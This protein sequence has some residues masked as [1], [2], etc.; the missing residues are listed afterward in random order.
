MKA[1]NGNQW[2]KRA[3]ISIG[4]V[5]I[6]FIIWLWFI[7]NHLPS[8]LKPDESKPIAVLFSNIRVISMVDENLPSQSAQDV[9]IIGDRIA[10][11]GATG[12]IK[13]PEGVL[14]IDG[15]GYTLMPG[16]IDAHIHLNDE[17]EF[18]AY[19]AHGVTGLRNMSGYPFHLQLTERITKGQLL[20]PDFMTT[21]PIL[22]SSGPNEHILQTIV[23]T[24][25]EARSAVR[26]QHS[27]GYRHIKVYSNLTPKAFTTILEEATLLGMT[28]S[29][30]SP[31]GKRTAGIPREKPFEIPWEASLG[32]GL[33]T[34]EHIE[35]IV[36]HGLR[37]DLTR[38]KMAVL[39]ET[40]AQSGEAVTPTLIAHKRLVLIAQSKGAY[41]TRPGSDMIN[42]LVTWFSQGALEYWSQMDP[43]VY[44]A[45]H[46]EFFLKATGLLHQ[47]GVPLLT[48]TDSGSFGII[49]GESV[50]H[51]LE[52]LVAAGLSPF[53]ALRS[54]TRRNAEKLGFEKTGMIL[55]GYRANLVLLAKDPLTDVS[56][57]EHP[58]GVMI[59]GHWLEQQ[60]LDAL[61]DSARSS[62]VSSFFRSLIRVI[63]MKLTH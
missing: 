9:L 28:I 46:A 3:G 15:E 20:A 21:G 50:A 17:L 39:A 52:L 57:V 34:L 60:E 12:E 45:P 40:I 43:S 53:D 31:E 1:K 11:I 55:S 8:T 16:L 18:A 44:E 7:I 48:G 23:N 14:L 51:E 41:L 62:G 5:C 38:E 10:E 33:I 13:A 49:P 56:V 35:T 59:G 37:D 54:V 4:I 63:E 58:V 25:D 19:L 6:L 24:A 61:K 42:P 30:H 47:A 27:A 26:E 32:K 2:L 29:G 36:W 22:N